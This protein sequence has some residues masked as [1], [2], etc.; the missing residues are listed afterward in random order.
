MQPCKNAKRRN[1]Y[2]E[3][4][5]KNLIS[6]NAG[7]EEFRRCDGRYLRRDADAVDLHP[8][9]YVS[10]KLHVHDLLHVRLCAGGYRLCSMGVC[11]C[12]AGAQRAVQDGNIQNKGV[13]TEVYANDS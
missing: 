5:R 12:R 1:G 11:S 9:L 3:I 2:E 13:M 7:K 10:A 6:G 8:V 4:R